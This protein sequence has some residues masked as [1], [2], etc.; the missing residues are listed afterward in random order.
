[1]SN[2]TEIKPIIKRASSKLARNIQVIL[3]MIE[4]ITERGLTPLCLIGFGEPKKNDNILAWFATIS[5]DKATKEVLLK[6]CKELI[7]L[8]EKGMLHDR[9]PH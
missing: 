4:E 2:K 5:D 6:C 7:E 1:M 8:E 9:P 3:P